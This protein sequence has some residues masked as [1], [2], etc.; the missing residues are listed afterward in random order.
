MNIRDSLVFVYKSYGF[1]M[2]KLHA[3]IL[4]IVSM[5][6]GFKDYHLLIV[7]CKNL[8]SVDIVTRLKIADGSQPPSAA[9]NIINKL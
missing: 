1:I 8:I 6:C 4:D 5:V 2:H 9:K 7:T 3:Y